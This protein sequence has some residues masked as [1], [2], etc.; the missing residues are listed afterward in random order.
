MFIPFKKALPEPTLGDLL[1]PTDALCADLVTTRDEAK[2]E[3]EVAGRYRGGR[4]PRGPR[5]LAMS[6]DA[7]VNATIRII[8]RNIVLNR[9]R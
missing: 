5:Y 8:Q 6:L 7:K 9:A 4:P 1:Q 3:S 2:D